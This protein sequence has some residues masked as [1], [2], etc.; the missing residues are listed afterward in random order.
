MDK[1]HRQSPPSWGLQ[2]GQEDSDQEPH[3]VR[4]VSTPISAVSE[5]HVVCCS[6]GSIRQAGKASGR[7]AWFMCHLKGGQQEKEL[8]R[9]QREVLLSRPGQCFRRVCW[10]TPTGSPVPHCELLFPT[11]RSEVTLVARNWPWRQYLPLRKQQM[12]HHRPTPTPSFGESFTNTTQAA[13]T[14]PASQLRVAQTLPFKPVSCRNS[15][16]NLFPERHCQ[17]ET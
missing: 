1:N 3:Q 6:R 8:L 15:F 16:K 7:Q 17:Q 9:R 10:S 11:P 2:T 12:L 13:C 14:S 4:G 5:S